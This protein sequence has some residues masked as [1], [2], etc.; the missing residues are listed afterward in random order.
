MTGWSVITLPAVTG[1]TVESCMHFDEGHNLNTV[2]SFHSMIKRIYKNYRGVATA[3]LN[4]YNTLF[5]SLFRNKGTLAARLEKALLSPMSG[6]LWHSKESVMM[7]GILL[8]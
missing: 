1:C 8:V 4:R 7:D 3:Y 6:R 2:N 5:S